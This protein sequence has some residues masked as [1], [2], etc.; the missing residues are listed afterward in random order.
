MAL[1]GAGGD[2]VAMLGIVVGRT[3]A[4]VGAF[5]F[6]RPGFLSPTLQPEPMEPLPELLVSMGEQVLRNGP[7]ETHSA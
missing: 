5:A 6:D 4:A 2:D 3:L 7:L 1:A